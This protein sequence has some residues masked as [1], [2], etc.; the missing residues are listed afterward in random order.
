MNDFDENILIYQDDFNQDEKPFMPE[1]YVKAGVP[2]LTSYSN[3]FGRKS[4]FWYVKDDTFV[5]IHFKHIQLSFFYT[6]LHV[7][8]ISSFFIFKYQVYD[9]YFDEINKYFIFILLLK[10]FST[11]ANVSTLICK[12]YFF[13]T[14]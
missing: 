14:D 5:G 4:P 3:L 8:L 13:R 10:L 6:T 9:Y 11:N 7:L 1:N 2:F 12:F